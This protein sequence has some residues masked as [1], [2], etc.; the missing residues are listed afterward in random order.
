MSEKKQTLI[1]LARQ[2]ADEIRSA[3]WWKKWG[4]I[5]QEREGERE[6]KGSRLLYCGI[7]LFSLLQT[8]RQRFC[9]EKTIAQVTEKKKKKRRRRRREE[10]K[11]CRWKK[12]IIE[13]V[14][15]LFDQ[16]TLELSSFLFFLDLYRLRCRT[17]YH[18]P[19]VHDLMVHGKTLIVRLFNW[20]KMSFFFRYWLDLSD[21][22]RTV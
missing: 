19:F 1:S 11:R 6:E 3:K 17:L 7:S 4:A 20:L 22:V 21:H 14:W 13:H 12:V 10:R 8:S 9:R 16:I 18:E 2:C 5:D 15:T